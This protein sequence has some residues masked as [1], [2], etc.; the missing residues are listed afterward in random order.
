MRERAVATRLWS[1]EGDSP[2]RVAAWGVESGEE[3]E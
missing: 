2:P 1:W 3:V